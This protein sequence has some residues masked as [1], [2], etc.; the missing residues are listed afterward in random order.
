MGHERPAHNLNILQFFAFVSVMMASIKKD[1]NQRLKEWLERGRYYGHSCRSVVKKGPPVESKETGFENKTVVED[2]RE[3]SGG[4]SATMPTPNERLY[5]LVAKMACPDGDMFEDFFGHFCMII[6][7][8]VILNQQEGRSPTSTAFLRD[9]LQPAFDHVCSKWEPR[10]EKVT[11][12]PLEDTC[13]A[14]LVTSRYFVALVKDAN[15]KD[16]DGDDAEDEELF[17]MVYV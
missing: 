11:G 17:T 7:S 14:F 12:K 3:P 1:S 2:Q 10:I 6:D 5:R 4:D 8:H 13:P 9:T 16:L 15:V